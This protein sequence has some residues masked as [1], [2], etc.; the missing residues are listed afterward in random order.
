MYY[1]NNN[2]E[3]NACNNKIR[4]NLETVFKLYIRVNYKFKVHPHS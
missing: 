1:N 4:E 3:K 2:E